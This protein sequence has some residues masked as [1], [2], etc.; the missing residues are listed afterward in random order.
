MLNLSFSSV[1][2][3]S[4]VR[5]KK[6]ELNSTEFCAEFCTELSFSMRLSLNVVLKQNTQ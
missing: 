6:K 4:L 2:V 1:M 3:N 5:R